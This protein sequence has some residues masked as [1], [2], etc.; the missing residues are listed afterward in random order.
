MT[1]FSSLVTTW[2][3]WL[4]TKYLKMRQYI[5]YTYIFIY[6]RTRVMCTSPLHGCIF[7][8]SCDVMAARRVRDLWHLLGVDVSSQEDASTSWPSSFGLICVVLGR[9]SEC[10]WRVFIFVVSCRALCSKSARSMLL[11]RSMTVFARCLYNKVGFR[12]GFYVPEG[13]ISAR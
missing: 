10:C 8:G 1:Q 7:T 13:S 4:R 12:W 6:S 11:G 3:V 9:S 5:I 2:V